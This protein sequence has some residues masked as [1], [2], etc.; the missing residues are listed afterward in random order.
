M[1]LEVVHSNFYNPLHNPLARSTERWK[2][3]TFI[4]KVIQYREINIKDVFSSYQTPVM[5][6]LEV[7]KYFSKKTLSDM[8]DRV[9]NT[10]INNLNNLLTRLLYVE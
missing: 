10:P 4:S 2:L 1:R 7:V 5:E 6:F 8:F 3:S 9:L